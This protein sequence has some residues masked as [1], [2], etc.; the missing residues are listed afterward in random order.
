MVN[1]PYVEIAIGMCSGGLLSPLRVVAIGSAIDY[2]LGVGLQYIVG[3][4]SEGLCW[5]SYVRHVSTTAHAT[6]LDVEFAVCRRRSYTKNCVGPAISVIF[7]AACSSA[8][9][10]NNPAVLL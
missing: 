6:Q 3:A 9:P 1:T 4:L 7:G 2:K 5:A 10:H 8:L